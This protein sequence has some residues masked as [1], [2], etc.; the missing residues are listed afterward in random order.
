MTTL[1][2]ITLVH[3]YIDLCS[4][5]HE[6][7]TLIHEGGGYGYPQANLTSQVMHI[8][9]QVKSVFTSVIV[10]SIRQEIIPHSSSHHFN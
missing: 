3:G 8:F 1:A 2:S 6:N 4:S 7:L 9:S 5:T 10:F